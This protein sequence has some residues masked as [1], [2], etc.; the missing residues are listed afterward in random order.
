MSARLNLDISVGTNPLVKWYSRSINAVGQVFGYSPYKTGSM[1]EQYL[2][3][4]AWIFLEKREKH[5]NLQ[6]S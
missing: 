3:F 5:K 4:A 6:K 1:A 2:I